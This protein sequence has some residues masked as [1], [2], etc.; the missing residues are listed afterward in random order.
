M[1]EIFSYITGWNSHLITAIFSSFKGSCFLVDN[2]T[3]VCQVFSQRCK[4]ACYSFNKIRASASVSSNIKDKILYSRFL[5]CQNLFSKFLSHLCIVSA[6]IGIQ[7]IYHL[8][9][10]DHICIFI[11][12]L[13]IK[14]CYVNSIIYLTHGIKHSWSICAKALSCDSFFISISIYKCYVNC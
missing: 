3:V 5:Q 2:R 8:T 4:E 10:S 9:D 1:P 7:I 12:F 13:P 14:I 6:F 11:Y